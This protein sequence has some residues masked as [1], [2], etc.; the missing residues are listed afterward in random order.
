VTCAHQ[1]DGKALTSDLTSRL[2]GTRL[3]NGSST[4]S[5]IFLACKD[6]GFPVGKWPERCDLVA[7]IFD[8]RPLNIVEHDLHRLFIGH[9][10]I[11]DYVAGRKCLPLEIYP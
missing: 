10:I 5:A 2:I 1:P 7:G 9:L 6:R 8:N 3:A 11:V 4:L